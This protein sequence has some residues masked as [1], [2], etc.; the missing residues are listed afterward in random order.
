MMVVMS[1][2][3]IITLATFLVITIGAGV[4]IFLTKGYTFSTQTKSIVG[5][6]IINITSTP[7][8][9]SVYIDGHLTTSTDATIPSLSP[10][11][12]TVRVIKEGFIPWE[13]K[14][15]VQEGLVT[16]L[17]V[18]LFPAIPTVYPLTTAGVKNVVLSPDQT[19]IAY[20]VPIATDSANLTDPI[21]IRRKAGV[22]VW[23]LDSGQPIIFA[24]GA[25]PHQIAESRLADY[26][27]AILRWSADSKQVLATVGNNNYVLNEGSFND[28]PRDITPV[29]DSTLKSWDED[30]KAA[31]SARVLQIQ[32]LPIRKLASDSAILKWAPDETKFIYGKTKTNGLKVYDLVLHQQYDL[33]VS[34]NHFWLADSRH[35]VLVEDGAIS[36]IDFDGSNKAVIYAGKINPNEVFGWPD[37]SK[38]VIVTSFPTPTAS[39][40][41]LYGINLK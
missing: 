29:L 3:F 37:S 8:A 35:I 32:N 17:K 10:K 6:G 22:W 20:V 19:K 40:P 28:N 15:K 34:K 24:R 23:S 7:N 27:N 16:A 18:T 39:A 5:T 11:D 14:V 1:K 13:K 25:Q 9:A 2:R 12:Y 31:D 30:K 33:P 4:A 36:I 21:A 41:N 26:S 38:L